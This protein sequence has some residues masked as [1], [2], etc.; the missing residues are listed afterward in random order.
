MNVEM[1]TKG[2]THLMKCLTKQTEELRNELMMIGNMVDELFVETEEMRVELEK[3]A[4]S[5][6]KK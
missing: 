3:M 1:K 2:M 5:E 6:K 4:R